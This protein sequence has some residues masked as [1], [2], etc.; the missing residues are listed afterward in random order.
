MNAIQANQNSGFNLKLIVG[1]SSTTSSQFVYSPT[2]TP[3]IKKV[4]PST[5]FGPTAIKIWGIHKI[6]TIG[7]GNRVPG[8]IF[9]ISLNNTVCG[10]SGYEFEYLAFS[11]LRFLTCTLEYTMEAGRYNL[12]YW[13]SQ[14]FAYHENSTKKWNSFRN[15]S[16]EMTVLPIIY[17]ISPAS[18]TGQILTING[19]GFVSNSSRVRVDV[20]GRSCEIRQAQSN[21]IQCRLSERREGATSRLLTNTTSTQKMGYI[22]GSGWNYTRYSNSYIYGEIKNVRSYVAGITSSPTIQGIKTEL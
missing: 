4:Y 19:T 5:I 10:R 14:G 13:V 7:D 12:S 22:A 20:D 21:R 17:K 16:Y 18:G 6:N 1:R 15:S 11:D 3:T 9:K 2:Y 8:E